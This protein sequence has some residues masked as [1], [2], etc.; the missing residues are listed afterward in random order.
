MPE[1]GS[2]QH[3]QCEPFFSYFRIAVQLPNLIIDCM[4][5]SV[6]ALSQL[7]KFNWMHTK[8]HTRL[9][10]VT[11]S[12]WN[13]NLNLSFHAIKILRRFRKN[14]CLTIV[15]IWRTENSDL[16]YKL[17]NALGSRSEW[18]DLMNRPPNQA[19]GHANH[20]SW[21]LCVKLSSFQMIMWKWCENRGS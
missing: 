5:S 4:Q 7:P 9:N 10:N 20:Y 18:W 6:W 8:Y 12:P 11:N 13:F 21:S 3:L 14:F 2:L 17:I 19:I 1:I 15:A 16:C